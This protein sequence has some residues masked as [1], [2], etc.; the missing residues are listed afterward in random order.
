MVVSNVFE[1]THAR[2][3]ARTHRPDFGDLGASREQALAVRV[4]GDAVID[5]DSPP[6]TVH[7][8]AHDILAVRV[9]PGGCR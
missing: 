5:D 8:Q 6:L 4:E 9:I 3:R 1:Y 7:V 2:T